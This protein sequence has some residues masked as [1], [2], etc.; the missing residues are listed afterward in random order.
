[1][2][3]CTLGV[4]LLENTLEGERVIRS[5]DELFEKVKK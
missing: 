5:Y 4:S 2:L 3:L 1:M